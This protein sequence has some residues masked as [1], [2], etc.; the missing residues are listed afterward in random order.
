MLKYINKP[1]FFIALAIG[2]IVLYTKR[3]DVQKVYIYPTPE[4]ANKIQYSDKTGTCFN[5]ETSEVKCEN[6]TNYIVQ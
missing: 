4:N 2:I 3:G 1:A 6:D 5:I